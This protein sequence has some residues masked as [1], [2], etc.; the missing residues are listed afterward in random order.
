MG[1]GRAAKEAARKNASKKRKRAGLLPN[2]YTI[3][4]RLSEKA[5]FAQIHTEFSMDALL[6]N[7]RTSGRLIITSAEP[8]SLDTLKSHPDSSYIHWD[9]T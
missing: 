4:R 7:P 1:S 5:A 3:P 6:I 2:A 8:L 9:G